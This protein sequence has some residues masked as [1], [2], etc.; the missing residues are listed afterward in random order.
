M[1]LQKSNAMIAFAAVCGL[2]LAEFSYSLR[3]KLVSKGSDGSFVSVGAV[4]I[5]SHS[6]Q[7]MIVPGSRWH[8][9]IP[10][11]TAQVRICQFKGVVARLQP[12]LSLIG[13][14]LELNRRLECIFCGR[15]S[16]RISD[17]RR[18]QTFAGELQ[19]L[20]FLMAS[21]EFHNLQTKIVPL[22]EQTFQGMP[23]RQ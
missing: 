2:C 16:W 1:R 22:V 5:L 4:G 13:N 3:V 12:C 20:G 9:M 23:P 19:S 21:A 10:P 18:F 8:V 14:V 15:R 6:P 11:I 17:K 7:R